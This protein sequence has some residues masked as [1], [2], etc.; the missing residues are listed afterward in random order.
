MKPLIVHNDKK[1]RK[2]QKRSIKS[3][4]AVD[5]LGEIYKNCEIFGLTGGQFSLIDIIS[6]CLN[7]T[8]PADVVISTWSAANADINFAFELL[9]NDKISN[10]RFIIDRSFQSRQ[11]L[12]CAALVERFGKDSIRVIRNH[13]KF[14]LI[15]NKNWSIVIRTS[16]NLNLNRRIENF[17]ISEDLEFY[18]HMIGFV[19][20]I[21]TKM[22]PGTNSFSQEKFET[23][24]GSQGVLDDSIHGVNINRIGLSTK[25]GRIE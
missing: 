2:I 11:P 6:H 16:M 25:K 10:L 3:L 9:D 1:K 5:G 17:E 19:D 15:K 8:G 12:Y 22:D 20:E 23:I 13:C 18:S 24:I 7:T 14:V 21:F 4:A